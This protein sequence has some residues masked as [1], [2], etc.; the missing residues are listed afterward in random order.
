MLSSSS[1][2][3]TAEM[4][5]SPPLHLRF[6]FNLIQGL[7][8]QAKK[9]TKSQTPPSLSRQHKSSSF[10]LLRT[11]ESPCQAPLCQRAATA[12]RPSASAPGR[13]GWRP[14]PSCPPGRSVLPRHHALVS[15][16]SSR[17]GT[18]RSLCPL[19]AFQRR[20]MG[21]MS[22]LVPVGDR[23]VSLGD[24]SP[25]VCNRSGQFPVVCVSV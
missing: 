19:L 16:S 20:K 4:P 10:S 13:D 21:K 2:G 5:S 24:G 17:S 11:Q 1:P 22:L 25:S 12:V 8:S 3:S 14:S 7:P 15:S 6:K 9:K 23:L 18:A